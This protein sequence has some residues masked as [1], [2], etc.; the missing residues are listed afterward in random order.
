[1][2]WPSTL[3]ANEGGPVRVEELNEQLETI[4]ASVHLVSFDDAS[5][6]SSMAALIQQMQQ[7]HEANAPHSHCDDLLDYFDA[8]AQHPVGYHPSYACR[9]NETQMRGFDAWMSVPHDSP[10]AWAVDPMR[11]RNMTRF[12][13]GFGAAHVACDAAVYG[14]YEHQLN[15]LELTSR[16]DA[17]AP[18]DAAVP[19]AARIKPEAD[20]TTLGVPSG[21]QFDT[22]LV[23]ADGSLLLWRHSTGLV[24]DWMSLHGRDDALEAALDSLWPHWLNNDFDQYGTS[25]EA[26]PEN[27]TP[28]PLMFCQPNSADCCSGVE[29]CGLVCRT[30]AEEGP[31]GLV[32]SVQGICVAEGTCF[33]HYHCPEEQLCSGEGVCVAARVYLQNDMGAALEAQLFSDDRDT[34]S[35]PTTGFSAYESIPDFARAHGRCSFRDWYHYQNL[36]RLYSPGADRLLHVPNQ[37]VQKTDSHEPHSLRAAKTLQKQAHACDRS[38][39]HTELGVCVNDARERIITTQLYEQPVAGN[40]AVATATA[41]RTWQTS[42]VS[43]SIRFCDMGRALSLSNPTNGFLSPYEYANAL[44][45]QREDTLRHVPTTV[46]RCIDFAVCEAQRF[47]VQG[48]PV[49]GRVVR[50][51]R[52][53]PTGV[54]LSGDHRPYTHSDAEACFGGGHL[55]LSDDNFERCVV[56]RMTVPVINFLFTAKPD[57]LAYD[58]TFYSD[59]V[60][61]AQWSQISLQVA[62]DRLRQRCP[63]AFAQPIDNRVHEALFLHMLKVLASPYPPEQANS[64]TRY[65]NLLLPALF[66]IDAE[67]ARDTTRGF[68]EMPVMSSIPSNR[69]RLYTCAGPSSTPPGWEWMQNLNWRIGACCVPMDA[70]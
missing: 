12:S 22:P 39:Q 43:E 48:L 4:H 52:H 21:D 23:P 32:D 41:M 33:Q 67:R 68:D 15:P 42:D 5:V 13:T 10:R 24:R 46:G 30:R 11:Q 54:V 50:V 58:T 29:G 49:Q 8:E 25:E 6:L 31:E 57:L 59:D 64:V 61:S 55:L 34:C 28:P 37:L 70:F 3:P 36:T 62:F 40:T 16:W 26:L 51:V 66:G 65:V 19:R 47:S 17:T 35:L 9:R 20:M 69:P 38:Y 53:S 7:S 45:W 1:M 14:A 60:A 56:D 44:T 2:N 18:A 27:C 63:R